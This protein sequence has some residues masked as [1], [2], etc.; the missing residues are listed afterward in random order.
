MPPPL[1]AYYFVFDT[2][3]PLPGVLV[4]VAPD[5]SGA[6]AAARRHLAE[7][8]PEY[9]GS[10]LALRELAPLAAEGGTVVYVDEGGA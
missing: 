3:A 5:A 6:K 4:V 10:A 8:L 9:G 2:G 1:T 7:H